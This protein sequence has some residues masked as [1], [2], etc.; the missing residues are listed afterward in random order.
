MPSVMVYH[1]RRISYTIDYCAI[2]LEAFM[3]LVINEL[4]TKT[5]IIVTYGHIL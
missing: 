4:M 5:D 2:E 1:T 3:L